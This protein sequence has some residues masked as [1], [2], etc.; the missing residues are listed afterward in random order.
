MGNW[1][2]CISVKTKSV[3]PNFTL[4]T[5]GRLEPFANYALCD[6]QKD[7]ASSWTTSKP[8]QAS[9]L[10]AARFAKSD[11]YLRAAALKKIRSIVLVNPSDS[12]LGRL[13]LGCAGSLVGEDCDLSWTASKPNRPEP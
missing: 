12:Q 9:R 10:L 6:R 11:D 2:W 13:L 3:G 5:I 7:V 4:P 8:F 1:F